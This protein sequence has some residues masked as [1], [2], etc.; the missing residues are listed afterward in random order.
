MFVPQMGYTLLRIVNVLQVVC[1]TQ[2]CIGITWP[3]KVQ[4]STHC[5]YPNPGCTEIVGKWVCIYTYC[6]ISLCL[7]VVGMHL[8]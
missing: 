5:L 6:F 2:F 7:Y 1:C 4:K 3:L 8:C